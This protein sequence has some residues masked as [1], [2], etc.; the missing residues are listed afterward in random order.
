MVSAEEIR[1]VA[2]NARL[3]LTD[4]EVEQ[5]EEDFEDILG[6]FSTLDD[7]DTGGVE[8]SLHPIEIEREPREDEEEESLSQEESLSNTENT[9]KG[10]FKGPRSV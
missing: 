10:Y 5:L 1:D 8:P 6:A 3:N 2:E 4:E 7:I 9:E